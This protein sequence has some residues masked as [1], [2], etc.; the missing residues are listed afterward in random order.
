[1]GERDITLSAGRHWHHDVEDDG[2]NIWRGINAAKSVL[3]VVNDNDLSLIGK[4]FEIPPGKER[5]VVNEEEFALPCIV[6]RSV[7]YGLTLG[8]TRR[9]E[10]LSEHD[11]QRVGDRV[12]A[13]V[14]YPAV[15]DQSD[16]S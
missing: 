4:F 7:G 1:M 8:I 11:K 10:R 6:R 9:P 2:T 3:D 13:V 12:H 16:E 14:R 15:C 5:F